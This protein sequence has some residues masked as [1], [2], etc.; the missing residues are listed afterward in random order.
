M[1]RFDLRTVLLLLMLA[2]CAGGP[3]YPGTPPA[4]AL[5]LQESD[6][7]RA[8]EVERGRKVTI[9][10]QAN[11]STGYRWSVAS[12]GEALEQSGEPFHAA[13]SSMRGAGGG[14]YWSFMPVRAGKQELRFEYRRPW[15]RDKPPA[16]VLGYTVIVR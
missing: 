15:E 4:P 10:L 7:G 5:M 3:Q 11:P 13:E 14:E 9:R 12:T 6:A 16:R 8:I 2:G 1:L